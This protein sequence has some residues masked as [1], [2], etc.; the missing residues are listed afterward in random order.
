MS[1][2]RHLENVKAHIANGNI[3]SA[4]RIAE[5]LLRQYSSKAAQNK[6]KGIFV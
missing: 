1:L 3:D 4:K 5:S 6:I 2:D